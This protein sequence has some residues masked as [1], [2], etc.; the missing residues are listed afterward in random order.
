M[1]KITLRLATF[2]DVPHI[3]RLAEQL[4][5]PTTEEDMACRIA[6]LFQQPSDAVWVAAL[7]EGK[8]V[9]WIHL[10]VHR[11]L[12][13]SPVAMLGGLVVDEAHRGEGIGQKLMQHAE[14]WGQA[15]GCE[16][17][18]VKS[19]VTRQRAHSFYERLAYRNIKTQY[20]FRKD[21]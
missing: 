4:G 5:Y 16:A 17:V 3:T 10:Y 18:Y 14:T 1:D 12:V 6:E 21:L 13:D 11:S 20:A 8:V 7:P 2:E 19:N 9:G 15:H